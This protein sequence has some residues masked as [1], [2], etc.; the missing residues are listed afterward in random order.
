MEEKLLQTIAVTNTE[1]WNGT[2]WTEVNDLSLGRNAVGGAGVST[3]AIAFGGNTQP[4]TAV[5]E[6]WNVNFVA[7]RSWITVGTMNT[8]RNNL[9]GNGA[10][11]TTAGL[12]AGETHHLEQKLK[13][14]ME[15]IG[16]K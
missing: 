16:L 5:T 2:N 3:T 4:D 1:S 6:E 12:V 13:F 14:T 11:T 10:G 15:Q 7:E 9:N 8:S